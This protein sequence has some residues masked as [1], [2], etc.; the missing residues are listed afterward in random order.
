MRRLLQYEM[1]QEED[2]DVGSTFLQRLALEE[3]LNSSPSVKGLG[4]ENGRLMDEAFNAGLRF[5][6]VFQR[7]RKRYHAQGCEDT[8]VRC[9]ITH[10]SGLPMAMSSSDHTQRRQQSRGSSAILFSILYLSLTLPPCHSSPA[11]TRSKSK[12]HWPPSQSQDRR[13]DGETAVSHSLALPH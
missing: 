12:Q 7:H 5:L 4:G 6:N 8:L 1:L 13:Q 11:L 9:S 10:A 3:Q 2:G